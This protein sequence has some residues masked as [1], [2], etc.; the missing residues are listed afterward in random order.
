MAAI[1]FGEIQAGISRSRRTDPAKADEIEVWANELME[2][3]N[4]I[5]AD[6]ATYRLHAQLMSGRSGDIYEDAMIAATAIQHRLTLATRNVR[7]FEQF[8]VETFNPFKG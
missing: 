5:S 3:A 6:A 4:I 1:S 8:A 7:D 2:T